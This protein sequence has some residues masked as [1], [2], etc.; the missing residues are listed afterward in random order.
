MISDTPIFEDEYKRATRWTDFNT[1]VPTLFIFYHGCELLLK[2]ILT[3]RGIEFEA[4]HDLKSFVARLP[5]TNIGYPVV[6]IVLKYIENGQDRPAF[7]KH[8][9]FGNILSSTNLLYQALRRP[10]SNKELQFD[11]T[12]L[13]HNEDSILTEVKT[14]MIYTHVAL[15]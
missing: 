1:M 8:F 7:L 14:T 5:S 3:L 11:L 2:A 12:F 4:K 15:V 13:E 9:F 10:E 6:P